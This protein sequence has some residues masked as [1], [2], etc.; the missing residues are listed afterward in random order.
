MPISLEA[1]WVFQLTESEK[2]RHYFAGLRKAIFFLNLLPLFVIFFILYFSFWD[3]L[4]AFY[5]CLYGLVVSALLMEG[6][7]LT[8][9]KIP[10]A[11]SYLPGKEKL[12]LLWIIYF[13]LFLAFINLMAWI[14]SELLKSHSNFLIFFGAAILIILGVRIYQLLFFYRKNGIK[15]EEKPEPALVTLDY[16]SPPHQKRSL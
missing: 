11:C 12:Q 3:G 7:F 9:C 2:R 6:F 4:T 16:K 14:E 15:Y 13:F 10:F 8:Y 5:H 1:N